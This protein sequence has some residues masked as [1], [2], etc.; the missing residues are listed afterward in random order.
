MIDAYRGR[1]DVALAEIRRADFVARLPD[2]GELLDQVLLNEADIELTTGNRI[3]AIALLREA[4]GL[5]EKAHPQVAT[6]AWRY[7]VWDSVNAQLIAATGD[8]AGAQRSL[9]AAQSIIIERFG[10]NGFFNML[11]KRRAQAIAS[12]RKA[13]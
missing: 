12:M 2:H 8:V 13:A 4:K 3:K 9:A 11:A 6:D 7:A 10:P 5:L 1:I